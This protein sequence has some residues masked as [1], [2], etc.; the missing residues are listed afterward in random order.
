MRGTPKQVSVALRRRALRLKETVRQAERASA[1]EGKSIA[2]LLSSGPFKAAV[3]RAMGH[4]YAARSPR[5]P[6][7]PAVIN[8]QTGQFKAAWRVSGPRQTASGLLTRIT[9]D[10]P[11]AKFLFGGTARMIAR[12]TLKRIRER[13]MRS[14]KNRFAR[15]VSRAM[16]D[17]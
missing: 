9:N 16:K 2:R 3:L 15:A 7:D 5:P 1:E 4:P 10:S 6:M 17:Q 8:E 13:L 11:Y 14:R 12:P